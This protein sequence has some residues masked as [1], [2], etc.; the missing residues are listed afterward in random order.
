MVAET[1]GVISA[2]AAGKAGCK[3]IVFTGR[4]IALNRTFQKKVVQ[5]IALFGKK[6]VIPSHGE[7]CTAIG[8]AL[9]AEKGRKHG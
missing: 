5:T 8:A 9:S 3:E 7:Y 6:A 4:P 2:L 1:I